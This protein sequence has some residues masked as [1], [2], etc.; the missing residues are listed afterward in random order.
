M[1]S[2][3]KWCQDSYAQ[4]MCDL[5]EASSNQI[6]VGGLPLHTSEVDLALLFKSTIGVISQ[7]R[8]MRFR[9]GRSRGFGFVQFSR[10]EDYLRA[11]EMKSFTIYG[12]PIECRPSVDQECAAHE[13]RTL[14]KRKLIVVGLEASVNE[15]DC[16]S[17]FAV[18]GPVVR[19][20][21][22][23]SIKN[24]CPVAQGYVEFQFEASIKKVLG[25][26]SAPKVITVKSTPL[27]VYSAEAKSSST[28][29]WKESFKAEKGNSTF[30]FSRFGSEK[31]VG[32]S[33]QTS[34]S[35]KQTIK[36]AA[37]ISEFAKAA[38]KKKT[39][40]QAERTPEANYRLNFSMDQS[41]RSQHSILNGKVHHV[42]WLTSSLSDV[43]PIQASNL[44]MEL[45]ARKAHQHKA[46]VMRGEFTQ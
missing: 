33:Q 29:T 46:M 45:G 38:E 42:M 34:S 22:F 21:I 12:V 5:S 6:F 17:H 32:L 16:Q 18:Y 7:A 43:T 37:P 9:D 14:Q 15:K 8:I 19:V 13:A 20:K 24:C 30:M 36:N 40:A 44:W 3:S 25:N 27:L 23:R 31:S 11:L 28:K 4:N 10:T 26:I 39:N 1:N 2:K 35:N 41:V